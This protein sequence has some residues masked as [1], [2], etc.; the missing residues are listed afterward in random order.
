[1]ETQKF[2]KLKVASKFNRVIHLLELVKR[3][4]A[5][6]SFLRSL[7]HLRTGSAGLRRR[8][9]FLND[10]TT[11]KWGRRKGSLNQLEQMKHSVKFWSYFPLFGLLS[12][13]IGGESDYMNL[14][15]N[16]FWTPFQNR[17]TCPYLTWWNENF[18]KNDNILTFF[19]VFYIRQDF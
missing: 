6:T 17:K 16:H 3:I 8:S 9:R 19:K 12:L 13:N 7:N 1:M 10:S 14:L 2:K 5:S 18:F 15:K 4:F 11:W